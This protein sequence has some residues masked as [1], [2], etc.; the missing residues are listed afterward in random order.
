MSIFRHLVGFL[1]QGIS[2]T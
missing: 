2:P 1:G